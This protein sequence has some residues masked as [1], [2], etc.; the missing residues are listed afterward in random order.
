M[1][2]IIKQVIIIRKDLKLRR[3]KEISQGAHSAMKFLCDKIRLVLDMGDPTN[4]IGITLTEIERKWIQGL[5]TKICL[6]VNSEQ[7]LLNIHHQAQ[8]A[9]LTSCLIQDAGQTEFHGVPTNT[10][11]AIGP[12]TA[13]RID[14]ITSKLSLY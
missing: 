14:P 7:E 1:T 6:Q 13:E 10:C 2:A 8:E 9:G 12:D 5:F 3:G 11:L 4:Y